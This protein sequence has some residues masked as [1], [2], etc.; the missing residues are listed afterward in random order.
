M[1]Y[2]GNTKKNVYEK[3]LIEIKKKPEAEEHDYRK[4]KKFTN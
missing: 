3:I 4:E 1:Q 2:N